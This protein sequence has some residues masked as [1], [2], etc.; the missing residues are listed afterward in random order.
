MK[1]DRTLRKWYKL[2]NRKFFHGELTN[3]VCIRWAD[4]TEDEREENWEERYFADVD[5]ANDGRHEYVIVLSKKK[6]NAAIQTL[7]S[8]IHEMIHVATGLRD[9]HGDAFDKWHK[10]LTERGVFKKHALLKGRTIF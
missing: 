3:N 2:I 8:L 10:L 4:E 5:K 9:D 1:S 7:S 6:N